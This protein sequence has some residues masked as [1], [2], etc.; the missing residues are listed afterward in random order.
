MRLVGA[1]L[2]VF[3]GMLLLIGLLASQKAFD[4]SRISPGPSR[5]PSSSN[6][7]PEDGRVITDTTYDQLKRQ[8]SGRGGRA[9]V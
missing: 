9:P 5:A 1:G 4:R 2:F 6:R 8:R 3:A 7:V